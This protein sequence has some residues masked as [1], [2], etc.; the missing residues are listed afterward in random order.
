VQAVK[1]DLAMV[2]HACH[3]VRLKVHRLEAGATKKQQKKG[4]PTGRPY[5]LVGSATLHL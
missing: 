3:P 4:D 1:I 5:V 2:A